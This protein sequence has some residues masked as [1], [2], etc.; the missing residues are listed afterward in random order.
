MVVLSCPGVLKVESLNL[1]HAGVK[2]PTASGKNTASKVASSLSLQF[3]AH[4]K[5]RA[6]RSRSSCCVRISLA[7]KPIKPFKERVIA[8]SKYRL[9]MNHEK[10]SF[11]SCREI[12]LLQFSRFCLMP[13]PLVQEQCKV[14]LG[15]ALRFLMTT[16]HRTTL[17]FLTTS[18]YID[19]GMY[20]YCSCGLWHMASLAS[21]LRSLCAVGQAASKR[22]SCASRSGRSESAKSESSPKRR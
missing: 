17:S 9:V 15:D 21:L 3:P 5:S 8:Y 6:H 11:C 18:W 2:G 1:F 20:S 12:F 10:L 19:S 7:S 14:C 16:L 22:P 13:V 4:A